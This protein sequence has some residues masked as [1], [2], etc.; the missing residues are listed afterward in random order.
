MIG[1]IGATG[2]IGSECTKIL[3]DYGIKDIKLGYRRKEKVCKSKNTFAFIDLDDINTCVEFVDGCDCIINCSGYSDSS[4]FNLIDTV[5]KNKCILID[6]SYYNFYEKSVF[7]G[8][9]IYHG[10]G[11][12][13]GLIEALPVIIS[14]VFDKTLSFQMYYAS[15]GEFTYNAAKEYLRYLSEDGFYARSILNSG[16]IEPYLAGN[17]TITLPISSERWVPFPYIDKRTLKVCRQ[18]G[19]ENAIFYMCIKNGYVC[20][21]L[22]NIRSDNIEN[23]NVMAQK[24][25][26]LSNLDNIE[27]K[28]FGGFILEATGIKNKN[29]I[30]ANMILKSISPTRLTALTVAAVSILALEHGNKTEIKDMSE[31]PLLNSLLDK[32]MEMDTTFY[33]KLMKGTNLK[34]NNIFEGEI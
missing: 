20:N 34:L 27:K 8:G 6:L 19:V 4:I 15:N 26:D 3:N 25:V 1:I 32:M 11:S 22:K 13:P 33:Y 29:T 17:K 12:S 7:E 16:K 2:D 30:D 31:F 18:I 23:I 24:L 9:T 10:V 5:N 21:F 14:R 28:E